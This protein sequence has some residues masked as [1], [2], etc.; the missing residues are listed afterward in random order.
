MTDTG[1][2]PGD[3]TVLGQIAALP[4]AELRVL[5]T[6]GVVGRASLSGDE[7]AELADGEDVTQLVADL[8]RRGLIGCD[9]KQRYRAL[10]GVS[11]KIRQTDAALS[12]GDRL[13]QYMTTLAKGGQLTPERLLDD[14]EAVLGLTEWAADL[15]KW[16]R[17]LELVKTLQAC[18]GIVSR[19]KE[20]LTLLER[21]R[22]AAR[23]LGDWQ[24]EVWVLQQLATTS[25]RAGDS[26]AARQYQREAD[27]LRREHELSVHRAKDDGDVSAGPQATIEA[28]GRAS[29]IAL[30]M[31]GLIAAAAAG[32]ATGYAIGNSNDSV[33]TTTTRVPVT[34]TADG[35][36]VT[37]SKTVTLPVTT[38]LSTTTVT[39]TVVSPPPSPPSSSATP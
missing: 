12:T 39:T 32:G 4:P 33:G 16:E 37:T 19:I 24:S 7:L 26:S 13:L 5:A 28:D 11:E 17:L 3:E 30:W 18:F 10:N 21:G 27:A 6:L 2:W 15:Q 1:D 38:V 8:E 20:W 14:A 9:K 23:A 22:S 29:R 34:V 35:R 36:T 31:L 25:A